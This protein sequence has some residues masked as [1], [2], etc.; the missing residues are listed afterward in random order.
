[1]SFDP[2]AIT[3]P[4]IYEA[5][6]ALTVGL[7]LPSEITVD[8]LDFAEY[9]YKQVFTRRIPARLEVPE[10]SATYEEVSC[11]YLETDRLGYGPQIQN[12]SIAKP[13]KV[14]FKIKSHDGGEC[15]VPGT[16]NNSSWFDAS[17]FRHDEAWTG[18]SRSSPMQVIKHYCPTWDIGQGFCRGKRGQ[19]EGDYALIHRGKNPA[20]LP[21]W[22]CPDQD[23][24]IRCGYKLVKNGNKLMWLLQQ[25]HNGSS[26]IAEHTVEWTDE[27]QEEEEDEDETP[28]TYRYIPKDYGSDSDMLREGLDP[29]IDSEVLSV[30]SAQS[31]LDRILGS[32]VSSVVSEQGLHDEVLDPEVSSAFSEQ[33][34]LDE[35]AKYPSS[36]NGKAF[37]ASLRKGD[38]IGVWARLM[39][40]KLRFSTLVYS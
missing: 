21:K 3:I 14:L 36:G 28:W 20:V 27:Y 2:N 32:E 35:L 16:Y 7:G 30:Y 13:R 29:N 18:K 25:N 11:L 24:T 39:V 22:L 19:P 10:G 34:V 1:M 33:S 31:S 15:G 6:F 17:I 26:N 40:R 12:V 8:I 9:W 37:V 23:E 38:R 4:E 5:H